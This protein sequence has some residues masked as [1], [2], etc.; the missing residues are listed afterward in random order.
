M[1]ME[2]P[3]FTL[4]SHLISIYFKKVYFILIIK[5]NLNTF[6]EAVV[7]CEMEFNQGRKKMD[8]RNISKVDLR[9]STCPLT[10]KSQKELRH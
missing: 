3:I 6:F 7:G 5:K 1:A 8:K 10:D 4:N 2:C 9:E